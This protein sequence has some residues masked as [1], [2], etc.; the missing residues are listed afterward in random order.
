MSRVR[1]LVAAAVIVR[2]DGKFLLAQRPAGKPYAGYWEFPGG[3]VEAGESAAHALARELHEELGIEV[4]RACPWITRDYDYEHAAVRL[5]FFRVLEWRG[6][7]HGRENQSFAWQCIGALNV[8]PMLPA[9]APVLRAL[10]LPHVYGITNAAELGPDLFLTRLERALQ[11]GLRLVQIREKTLGEP[12]LAQFAQQVTAL[13]HGHGARVLVNSNETLAARVGADGIHLTAR[14]L[15]HAR[16]R[17]DFPLV[18]ASCHDAAELR[19]AAAIGADF[20][21]AGPVQATPSHPGAPTLGWERLARMIEAYPLPVYA[22]GGMR[23]DDLT[24]AWE[25]GAHGIAMMRGAWK[26]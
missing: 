8:A 23:H 1:V 9:N 22:L 14:D 16:T 4:V 15:M 11:G 6:E 7:L 25:A 20:V 3:K 26:A 12:A 10:A 2:R 17:P 18:G 24:H 13:A 21:V 19:Q 5:H